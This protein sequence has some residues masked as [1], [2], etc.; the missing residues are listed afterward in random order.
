LPDLGKQ[1]GQKAGRSISISKISTML[2][3]KIA[4]LWA[5]LLSQLALGATTQFSN[6]RRFMFD[7]D[8]NLI[9]A[10]GSKINCK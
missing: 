7:V 3:S 5:G 4:L 6:E 8:G 2:F 1:R 10:Y 9:D